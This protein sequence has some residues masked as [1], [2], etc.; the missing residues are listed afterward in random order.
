MFVATLLNPALS[1]R[2]IW[3]DK[4]P[5]RYRAVKTY[6]VTRLRY[7]CNVPRLAQTIPKRTSALSSANLGADSNIV[8]GERWS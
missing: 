6:T 3:P 2:L 4:W 8:L 7:Q 5:V 1:A